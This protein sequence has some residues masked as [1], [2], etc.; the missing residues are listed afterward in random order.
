[1]TA[2]EERAVNLP[3][4]RWSERPNW[5]RPMGRLLDEIVSDPEVNELVGRLNRARSPLTSDP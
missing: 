2:R 1:M 5:Q 4:T 3:G